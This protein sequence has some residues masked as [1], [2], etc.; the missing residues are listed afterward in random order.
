MSNILEAEQRRDWMKSRRKMRKAARRARSRRQTMRFLLLSGLLVLGALGFTHLPWRLHNQ[1]AEI[2]VHGNA[3]V[4]REQILQALKGAINVPVYNLDPHQLEQRL[5]AL[6]AVRHAFVRRYALPHP[7]LVVEILEEHPW[8]SYSPDPSLPPTAV[9][10]QSGR[11]IPI[12]EFPSVT[13]P[14][15]IIYGQPTLKLTSHEVVQWASWID[16]IRVQ[17]GRPVSN[18]DMRQP[19]EVAVQDSDLRLKIGTP[20]TTLTR[21]LGRIASIMPTYETMKDKVVIEY[22]DLSL[23]NSIPLKIGKG[24]PHKNLHALAQSTGF[25]GGDHSA[26]STQ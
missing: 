15:L 25:S 14:E 22:V 4:T 26:Q 18:I 13:R 23:D 1:E 6:K 5:A 17:T 20:D 10:A 16:Y 11:F 12:S 24:V 7:K 3:V 8:A 2:V 19:F 21:R 9:I